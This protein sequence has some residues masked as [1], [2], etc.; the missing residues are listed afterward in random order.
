[1]I[2]D[3][4]NN[5]I[6]LEIVT[7]DRIFFS[8]EVYLVN[9]PGAD[10]QFGVLSGHENLFSRLRAG[11]VIILN[12]NNQVTNQIFINGGFAKINRNSLSVL[13]ED[14]NY[15]SE[16]KIKETEDKLVGIKNSSVDKDS[17]EIKNLVTLLDILKK[18]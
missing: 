11:L 1:M 12:Q 18:Q 2:Q 10:G 17:D 5:L 4:A 15:L 7:P 13:V 9:L 3:N 14:A 6:K 16:F 8:K